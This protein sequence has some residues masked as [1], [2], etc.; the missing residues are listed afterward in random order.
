MPGPSLFGAEIDGDSVS[1]A[2]TSGPCAWAGEVS[3]GGRAT[4]EGRGEPTGK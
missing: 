3:V 1:E 2:D 4:K